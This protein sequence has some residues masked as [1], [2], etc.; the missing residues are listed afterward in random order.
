MAVCLAFSRAPLTSPNG[1]DSPKGVPGVRRLSIPT[2]LLD[3]RFRKPNPLRRG[4][5]ASSDIGIVR[6][7]TRCRRER[8]LEDGSC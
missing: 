3:Q 2:E 7:P 6:K 8:E 5:V 1:C 4:S